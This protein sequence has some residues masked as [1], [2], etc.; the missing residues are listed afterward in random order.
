MGRLGWL[1]IELV[2]L[3][4]LGL[5]VPAFAGTTRIAAGAAALGI[6]LVFNLNN[7]LNWRY[8]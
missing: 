3:F 1:D 5:W 4:R 6:F 7:R 8:E 2:S